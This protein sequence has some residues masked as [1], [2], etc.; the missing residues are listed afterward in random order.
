MDVGGVGGGAAVQQT[1][2]LFK[3]AEAAQQQTIN[4]AEKMMAI[5]VQSKVAGVGENVDVTR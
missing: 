1:A 3:V 4:L 2:E 5:E